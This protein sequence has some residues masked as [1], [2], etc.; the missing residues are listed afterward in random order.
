M[1]A[2]A[3]VVA[4]DYSGA[5]DACYANLGHYP[6]LHIVQG[7]V[8]ALPLDRGMFP[9]VYSLGVL[10]HTPDVHGAFAALPSMLAPG[11]RLC[12]D[13]YMRSWKSRLLP[14]YWLRPVTVRVPQEKL[15]AFLQ[16]AVPV[17]MP[18][19]RWLS[20]V[21]LIGPHLRRIVPVASYEGTLP[22]SADQHQEW[23]LLDTFDWLAPEYDD[24][25]TRETVR[26]WLV[27][28]GLMDIE[29]A[30]PDHLV[31]RGRA[32]L[33]SEVAAHGAHHRY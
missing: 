31:G 22:L 23:A 11:G 19:S 18:V 24:P 5:V 15:F 33:R 2:G 20:H 14:Y 9:F 7:D 8:Y 28:A 21:P 16:R 12:V 3:N 10:Q 29:V 32:P 6:N 13:F 25:Q 17:M 1:G 27:D 30:K 4:L 26:A